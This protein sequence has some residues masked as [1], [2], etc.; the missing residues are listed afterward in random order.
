M[1]GVFPVTNFLHTP[2]LIFSVSNLPVLIT[3]CAGYMCCRCSY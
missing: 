2:M 3:K 1:E